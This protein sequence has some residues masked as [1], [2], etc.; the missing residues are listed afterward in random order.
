MRDYMWETRERD[1]V[2]DREG[3]VV[4][5]YERLHVKKRER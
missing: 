2:F 3:E 5:L 1:Y 4:A